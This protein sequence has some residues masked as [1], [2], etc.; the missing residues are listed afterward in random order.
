M[1]GQPP[2]ERVSIMPANCSTVR[3]P[4]RDRHELVDAPDPGFYRDPFTGQMHRAPNRT[5]W[6]GGFLDRICG[7]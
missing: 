1:T 6:L 3:V 2:P 4:R 7:G 5:S